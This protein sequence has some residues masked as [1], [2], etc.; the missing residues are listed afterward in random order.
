MPKIISSGDDI[1]RGER[2][3][4]LKIE[5][6]KSM[7]SVRDEIDVEKIDAI[8]KEMETFE[9]TAF[10]TTS[11]ERWEKFKENR[12]EKAVSEKPSLSE[13]CEE[14]LDSNIPVK[15]RS[16]RIL[17]KISFAAV[18]A[19]IILGI[20]STV[21]LAS[22]GVLNPII[23]WAGQTLNKSYN[24]DKND[25]SDF[26]AEDSG[27]SEIEKAESLLILKPQYLPEGYVMGEIERVETPHQTIYMIPYAY[28]SSIITYTLKIMHAG[29]VA[30]IIKIE[31]VPDYQKE[32]NFNGV[33]FYV[34]K[35]T[36]WY[37]AT[38]NQ[39]NVDYTVYGFESEDE[40]LKFIDNLEL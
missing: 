13:I 9:P 32:I 36:D 34:Y 10:S 27:Y 31:I 23:E 37:G 2:L 29:E 25:I 16:T 3:A 7:S 40:I 15:H 8:V 21:L 26:A 39:W 14:K 5:L 33:D 22:I 11:K 30:S 18:I 38:W 6:E 4:T 20:S 24:V 19:I 28:N 17:P 12:F 35:N 1:A